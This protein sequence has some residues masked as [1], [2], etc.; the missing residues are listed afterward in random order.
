MLMRK[1]VLPAAVLAACVPGAAFAQSS[2]IVSSAASSGPGGDFVPIT[3][4]TSGNGQLSGRSSARTVSVLLN[5]PGNVG[6]RTTPRPASVA[7]V[8][9]GL[10]ERLL[11][12]REAR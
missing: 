9:Q 5:S 6:A 8:L 10:R 1:W 7:Q 11:G 12:R 3:A 4:D 2:S